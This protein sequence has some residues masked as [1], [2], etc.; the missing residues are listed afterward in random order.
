MLAVNARPVVF[1]GTALF[2]ITFLAL[3]PFWSWLGEHGHRIWLWTA[4]AGTGLGLL[5]LPLVR[6]HT[7]EGRLG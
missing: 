3:L 2:F 6:K 7:G 1:V 5:A 4:L